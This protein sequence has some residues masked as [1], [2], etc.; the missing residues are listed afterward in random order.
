MYFSLPII[1][2]GLWWII[3]IMASINT[4]VSG[5]ELLSTV[6]KQKGW[7][8]W[9]ETYLKK[10]QHSICGSAGVPCAVVLGLDIKALGTRTE[11]SAAF[12]FLVLCNNTFSWLAL[13]GSFVPQNSQ[14]FYFRFVHIWCLRSKGKAMCAGIVSTRAETAFFQLLFQRKVALV[15]KWTSLNSTKVILLVNYENATGCKERARGCEKLNFSYGTAEVFQLI[16]MLNQVTSSLKMR[17][18]PGWEQNKL[19]LIIALFLS[20]FR[21]SSLPPLSQ[22]GLCP[23]LETQDFLLAVVSTIWLES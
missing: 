17:T 11:D 14:S 7:C 8:L 10:G 12:Y 23:C 3:T 19:V 2:D 16:G 6:S 13:Q 21:H 9:V 15:I 1:L 5:A 22:L 4:C 20:L 18:H